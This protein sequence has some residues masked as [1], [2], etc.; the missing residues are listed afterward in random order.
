MRPSNAHAMRQPS[1]FSQQRQ[2]RCARDVPFTAFEQ[3]NDM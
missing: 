3:D 2:G 1:Q